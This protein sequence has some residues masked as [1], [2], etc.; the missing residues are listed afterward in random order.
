MSSLTLIDEPLKL[1]DYLAALV[2]FTRGVPVVREADLQA[3]GSCPSSTNG[4]GLLE[5]DVLEDIGGV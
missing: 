4:L 5:A 1:A 2:K 3:R